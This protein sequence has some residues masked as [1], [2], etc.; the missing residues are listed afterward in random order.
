MTEYMPSLARRA[1]SCLDTLSFVS[2]SLI[3]SS[4]STSIAN[5]VVAMPAF[6]PRPVVPAACD[7]KG[8]KKARLFPAAVVEDQAHDDHG[9]C[10]HAD[11]RD[12]RGRARVLHA[13]LDDDAEAGA[14][15]LALHRGHRAVREMH[16]EPLRHAVGPHRDVVEQEPPVALG[17]A[18]PAAFVEFAHLRHELGHGVHGRFFGQWPGLTYIIQALRVCGTRMQG[19]FLPTD[20]ETGK[21]YRACV[22]ARPLLHH[23]N[24]PAGCQSRRRR[25]RVKRARAASCRAFLCR[26]TTTG[27]SRRARSTARTSRT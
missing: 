25:G 18:A 26:G 24:K 6:A 22:W 13:V 19:T 20:T 3:S 2:A 9:R 7:G 21:S 14:A 11:E 27:A 1:I 5:V 15:L 12:D 10:D 16:R 8:L 4:S 17:H 23:K